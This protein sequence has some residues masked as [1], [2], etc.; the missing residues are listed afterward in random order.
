M[1]KNEIL[2]DILMTVEIILLFDIPW[3]LNLQNISKTQILKVVTAFLE[4]II[5]IINKQK[6]VNSKQEKKKKL[7]SN[8]EL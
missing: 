4:K 7:Y 5:T 3:E 2:E 8:V 6:Q 1:K